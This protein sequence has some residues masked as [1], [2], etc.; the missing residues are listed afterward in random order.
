MLPPHPQLSLPIPQNLTFQGSSRPFSRRNLD[1]GLSPSKV[2]YS[3]HLDISSTVPL[4]TLALIYASVPSC[5][6]RS[7]NSCV[8]KLL[9]STTPPQCVLIILGL[10]S[11]GP[12]PSIQ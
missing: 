10:A 3:I 4:P 6:H 7:K 5:S 8:P 11:R 9:S 12:I 1:M 2:T